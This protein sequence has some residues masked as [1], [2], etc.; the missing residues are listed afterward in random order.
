VKAE[1]DREVA[2]VCSEIARDALEGCGTIHH[3]RYARLVA[4][5]LPGL[6]WNRPAERSDRYDQPHSI[7]IDGLA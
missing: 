4:K 5:R 7:E 2:E 6:L 3:D 1:D